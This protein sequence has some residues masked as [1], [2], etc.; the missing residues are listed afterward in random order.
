MARKIVDELPDARVIRT[1]NAF[2]NAHMLA[3]NDA[4]GFEVTSVTTRWELSLK[5]RA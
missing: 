5:A 2:S 3:I 1:G 4:M